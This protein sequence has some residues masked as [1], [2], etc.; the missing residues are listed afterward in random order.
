PSFARGSYIQELR[1]DV[2]G[3]TTAMRAALDAAP[4]ASDKA[5]ANYY[6]GELSVNAGKAT[7]ALTYFEAGIAADPSYAALYEGKARAEAALGMSGDAV[8]DFADAVGRVPQPTYV[9]EYADYLTSLGR[10]A[11]AA[12]QYKIFLAENALFESNGVQLDTDATLYYADH[13]DA[14][15]AL[16]IGG[17]GIKSRPFLEMQDAYGWALHAAGRDAEAAQWVTKAIKPG[18]RNALFHFH[19]GM[20]EKALGHPAKARTELALALQ[21]NPHFH[22]LQAPIARAA[23]AQV[24]GTA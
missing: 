8:K 13:G 22:P 19:L 5:F 15:K 21:I 16:R 7:K 9:L 1:G 2:A 4:N 12:R 23:L 6:L 17:A 18:M 20:I 24:G 3:A 10:T 11:E 14:A